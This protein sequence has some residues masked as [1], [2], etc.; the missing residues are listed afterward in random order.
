MDINGFG[1]FYVFF[2]CADCGKVYFHF[3]RVEKE[4]KDKDH[5]PTE[6]VIIARQSAER[7]S[8]DNI[9]GFNL[10]ISLSKISIFY[11]N[12][13]FCLNPVFPLHLGNPF[14]N[15]NNTLWEPNHIMQHM[16]FFWLLTRWKVCGRN[17]ESQSAFALDLCQ[18][19]LYN[20]V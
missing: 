11:L 1:L 12:F 15:S 6:G 3:L 8:Q 13:F 17:F 4:T 14:A 16:L 20:N 5:L 10:S 7:T 18:N 9:P 2:F 19:A